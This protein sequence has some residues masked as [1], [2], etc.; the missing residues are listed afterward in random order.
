MRHLLIA[1]FAAALATSALAQDR[2]TLTNGDVLTGTI[3]S[4]ADGK[5]VINSPVLGDVTVKMADI[6]DLMTQAQVDLQTKGGLLMKGRI[7]GIENQSLRLEGDT[8]PLAIDDIGFINPP[9][10]SEPV[11]TGSLKVGALWTDGNTDRRS[12]NAAFDVQRK[13]EIDR[14]SFDA[15]WQYSEDKDNQQFESD[16]VTPHPGWREWTLNERRVEAGGKYDYLLSARAYAL[17]NARAL[18]D[19]KANL[20]LRWTA[21][22]GLGYLVIDDGT[23]LFQVEAGLAYFDETYR[24]VPVGE[25][26]SDAYLAARLAYKYTRQ[27]S[28]ATKLT[29]GVE[30]FPSLEDQ[31]DFYMQAKTELITTLTGNLIASIA[32]VLD[33]DNTPSPDPTRSIERVDNRVLLSIGLS[34]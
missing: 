2:V 17:A 18:G 29:H 19:T 34:F 13:S 14:I 33:Y 12:V 4:M 11:W 25:P 10:K 32:H 28:E 31:D 26:D 22:A 30:A 24:V 16:G 1:A 21:G 27:L 5:L 20:E 3:K 9:S 23:T 6:N 15:A 7:L 8:K